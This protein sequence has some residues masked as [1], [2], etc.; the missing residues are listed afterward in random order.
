MKN[1]LT[2]PPNLSTIE[3][4]AFA[5]LSTADAIYIP[6]TVTSIADDAFSESDIVII[7]S[8]GSYAVEWAEMNNIP[9]R[10]Q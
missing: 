5:N 3:S 1:V 10:V 7:A 9:Y 6:D 2:L 8:S 4:G